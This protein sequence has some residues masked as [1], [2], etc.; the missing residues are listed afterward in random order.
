MKTLFGNQRLTFH[1]GVQIYTSYRLYMSDGMVTGSCPSPPL[2]HLY[3]S[4]SL[5]PF[6]LIRS[7][8]RSH[9][10]QL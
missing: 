3:I 10:L 9:L 2:L 6:V 1:L 4:A 7:F 5:V 8:F